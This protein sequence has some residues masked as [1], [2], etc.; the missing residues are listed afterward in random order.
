L[1]RLTCIADRQ[2]FPLMPIGFVPIDNA[3][4]VVGVN[5]VVD[6]PRTLLRYGI[7]AALIRARIALNRF[8]RLEN[9]SEIMG[10]RIGPLSKS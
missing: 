9:N 1:L 5:L 2:H 7:A 10:K 4:A 3:A 6:R 8:A